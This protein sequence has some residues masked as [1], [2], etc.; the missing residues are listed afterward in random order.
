MV[1]LGVYFR[2]F[3][4]AW[5]KDES[6]GSGRRDWKDGFTRRFD[7]YKYFFLFVGIKSEVFGLV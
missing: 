6:G 2:E 7:V 4:I 5:R 3:S 1:C